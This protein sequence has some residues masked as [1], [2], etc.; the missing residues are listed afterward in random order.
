M[1]NSMCYWS[2]P[3]HQVLKH[4]PLG[5]LWLNLLAHVRQNLEAQ[6]SYQK[7]ASDPRSCAVI[8]TDFCATMMEEDLPN[9]AGFPFLP[10]CKPSSKKNLIDHQIL[11]TK[12]KNAR[13][14]WENLTVDNQMYI[15][16]K[17]GWSPKMLINLLLSETD[18]QVNFLPDC[19]LSIESQWQINAIHGHPVNFTL[20]A[21]PVP[22]YKRVTYCTHIL[23]I[24]KSEGICMI[25]WWLWIAFDVFTL[26]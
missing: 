2:D 18:S 16:S 6:V 5:R 14:G 12:T 24:A 26:H 3:S 9:H 20:P 22:P 19:L 23:V 10:Y 15:P 11:L 4:W 21:G 13:K 7:L 8:V 1:C 17:K 25:K